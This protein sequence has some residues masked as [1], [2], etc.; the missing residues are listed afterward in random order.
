MTSA[1]V[2]PKSAS[3][4]SQSTAISST[5]PSMSSLNTSITLQMTVK[6]FNHL[7]VIILVHNQPLWALINCDVTLN[8]VFT[9]ITCALELKSEKLL[10]LEV[11]EVNEKILAPVFTKEYFIIHTVF[12]SIIDCAL[13]W[14]LALLKHDIILEYPWLETHNSDINWK[15]HLIQS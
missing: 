9:L 1:S 13:F 3:L 10:T 5:L 11:C 15:T 7:T 2:N 8:F 4:L 6:G 12:D 14:V